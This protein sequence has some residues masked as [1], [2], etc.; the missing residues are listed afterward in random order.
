MQPSDFVVPP[1]A[2]TV[3]LADYDP[4]DACGFASKE[5]AHE[6]LAADVEKIA[7]LQDMF[8]AQSSHAILI[9]LQGMDTAGKDGIIKHVMTGLN[10]QGV[11]VYGFRAPT[12]TEVRHDFLWRESKV[13]P[14]RGRIA[15]FNRSYYEEVLVVRVHPEILA[16]QGVE[17]PGSHPWTQRYEDINAFERHLTRCGTTVLK[18]Y[19]HLSKAEQR[20]R[21]LSR[22]ETPHKMW[23]AS[24]TDLIGHA[25][26]D[27]YVEAYEA[28]LAHTSTPWAP[29]H[30][31]PADRKWVS[32]CVVGRVLAGALEG[33]HLQYPVPTPERLQTIQALAK[34][35]ESE[36]D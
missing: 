29:W 20:K 34:Q 35:L 10:P 7:K 18:F 36:P 9:V 6:F 21:L 31:V 17:D 13:L 28:M 15:I 4:A 11:D 3:R 5:K 2:G 32:R 22:L 26:W 27:S 23:K 24:D 12:P 1:G 33:L 30:V 25:E 19:L 8:G 16:A 14:E